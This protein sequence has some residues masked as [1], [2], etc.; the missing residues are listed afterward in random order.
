VAIL[1]IRDLTGKVAV[2]TGAGRGIGRSIALG[3]SIEKMRLVLTGRKVVLLEKLQNEL[4]EKKT[5]TLVISANLEDQSAPEM[6]VSKTIEK[7]GQIDVLVNNAGTAV[8]KRIEDTEIS[9]WNTLINVN[10]RAPFFL[11]KEA[12][13]YLKKS[14]LGHV[15]NIGSVV[16][17]KG[18][19]SQAAY[20]AS[21]HALLGFS[22]VLAMEGRK[23]GITVNVISPGGVDTELISGMR[24]DINRSELIDP[25]EI[26]G[27]VVFLLKQGGN[28]A[29]DHI[30][31]R[32]RTKE[33]WA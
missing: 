32:R 5:D 33:P 23:D 14:L 20:T 27:L 25:G 13:K 29:I 15:I 10:A 22:K 1:N 31:V 24:P 30:K 28:A 16:D 21:K 8:S 2:I 17:T 7:Y 12:M 9:D 3:L 18:Y 26:A 6:I 19:V 11:T 4:A